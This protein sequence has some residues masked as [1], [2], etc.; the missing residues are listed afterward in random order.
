MRN[1]FK[2]LNLRT[3]A[4]REAVAQALSMANST[5]SALAPRTRAD[6]HDIM[7]DEDRRQCYAGVVELYET[8]Y[9]AIG[10]LRESVGKD[11]HRWHARLSEFETSIDDRSS[12]QNP[13]NV[14]SDA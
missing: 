6:A 9:T 2:T 1:Y 7:L 10:C 8:M 5:G 3:A 11:T 12:M 13:Q 4:P 14:D